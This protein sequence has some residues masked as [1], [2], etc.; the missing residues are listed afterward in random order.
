VGASTAALSAP[1]ETVAALAG[2][3]MARSMINQSLGATARDVTYGNPAK[4][5]VNEGI[6]SVSTGDWEAYKDAL[7]AGQTPDQAA[8]AAGGRFAAIFKKVSSLSETVNNNLAQSSTRLSVDDIINKPLDDATIGIIS[9]RSMTPL[10]KDA[11][12]NQLGGL[13]KS[14][15]EGLGSE[16]SLVEA[17]RIK[18]QIGDRVNWGGATAV[19]D[20][21]KPA[22]KQ[23]YGTIKDA[24]NAAAPD[25]AALNERLTNLMAAKNDVEMLARAEEVGRGAGI[26]RGVIGETIPGMIEATAGRTLPGAAA[27]ARWARPVIGGMVSAIAERQPQQ[28]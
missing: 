16:V 4:A 5:I 27:A 28:Q 21:V 26:A 22:Y 11:A 17:Q 23:V 1:F 3:K 12:L 25:T 18:H 15:T 2:T 20:E 14:L 19:T 7:R 10:E 9:N 8:Q 24:I 6:N 13:Q